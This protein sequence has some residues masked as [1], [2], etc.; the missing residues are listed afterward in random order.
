MI[1]EKTRFNITIATAISVA[2]FI[3]YATSAFNRTLSSIRDDMRTI[4]M[5]LTERIDKVDANTQDRWTRTAMSEFAAR[6]ALNNRELRIPD[7]KDP[8]RLL[9]EGPRPGGSEAAFAGMEIRR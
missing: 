7:P 6:L 5:E 3:V 4:R 1:S 9:S 2:G 8:A